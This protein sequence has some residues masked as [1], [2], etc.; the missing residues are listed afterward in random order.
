MINHLIDNKIKLQ[1]KKKGYQPFFFYGIVK[2]KIFLSQKNVNILLSY[3]FLILRAF[4]AKYDILY[5][6][7]K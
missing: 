4:L 3:V 1:Q 2:N 7:Y 5:Q 6:K